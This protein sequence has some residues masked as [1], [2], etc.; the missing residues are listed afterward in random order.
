MLSDKTTNIGAVKH[1]E[2]IGD[3]KTLAVMPALTE[4]GNEIAKVE[5]G[6]VQWDRAASQAESR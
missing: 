6:L 2:Q 5:I 3:R 1:P 4:A